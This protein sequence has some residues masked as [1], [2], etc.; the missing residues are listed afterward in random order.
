MV[1]ADDHQLALQ[2]LA[3]AVTK[4]PDLELVAQAADGAAALAAIEELS[5]DVALVDVRM[6]ELDGVELCARIAG[7]PELETRVVLLTAFPNSR[8]R[9]RALRA[10]AVAFLD[11]ESSRDELCEALVAAACN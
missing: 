1:I 4:H 6:P 5:P 10:G 7:E 9:E 3:R 8:V 2:G 11:K